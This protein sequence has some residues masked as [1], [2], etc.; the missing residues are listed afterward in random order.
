MLTRTRWL[1]LPALLVVW[2]GL[3]GPASAVYPPPIKDEGKFF[4][5]EMVDKANKKIKEIYSATKKDLVIET[6]PGIPE[7]KKLPEDKNKIGEFFAEWAKAR[8]AELGV[9]GV[10]VLICKSPH[11]LQIQPD[12]ATGKRAFTAKDRERMQQKMIAAF[13]ESKFDVGL[14]EGIDVVEAALRANL[15]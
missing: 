4:S 12:A 11:R 3:A 10:Y 8:S 13:K 9:N 6:Y 5:A 15:K 14:K 1:L 2:L 7:G